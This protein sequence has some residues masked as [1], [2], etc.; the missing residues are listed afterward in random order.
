M[1][2]DPDP[3]VTVETPPGEGEPAEPETPAAPAAEPTDTTDWK[4]E[5]LKA[6]PKIELANRVLA[7]QEERERRAADTPG[8]PAT[9]GS[10]RSARLADIR[11]R[12]EPLA[13]TDPVAALAIELVEE[14]EERDV[15]RDLKTADAFTLSKVPEEKQGALWQFYQR[16]RSHFGSLA[17]AKD[18]F[19]AREAK[20]EAARL[21]KENE[22]LKKGK[23]A[24]PA[25]EGARDAARTLPPAGTGGG[26]DTTTPQTK[27]QPMNRDEFDA[28][29]AAL[30]EAGDPHGARMLQRQLREHKIVLRR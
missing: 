28:K 27:A 8:T 1:H 5:Y 30:Y 26:R 22:D 3:N 24:A 21:R 29:V 18:A 15:K 13:S 9:D 12:V 14:L 10:P 4:A 6:K 7:E 2:A 19:E 25:D 16:N 11:K 20:A 23:G 17:A